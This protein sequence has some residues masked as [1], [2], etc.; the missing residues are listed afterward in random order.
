MPNLDTQLVVFNQIRSSFIGNAVRRLTESGSKFCVSAGFVVVGAILLS[1][2]IDFSE[3]GNWVGV[4]R[5]S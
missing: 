2:M 3:T 1:A 4:P 5:F